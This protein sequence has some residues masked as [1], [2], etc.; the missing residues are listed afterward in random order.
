MNKTRRFCMTLKKILGL[1]QCSYCKSFDHDKR[2]CPIKRKIE[3]TSAPARVGAAL[4]LEAL[5][6]LLKK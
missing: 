3:R 6:G 1:R 5:E 2:K 4:A